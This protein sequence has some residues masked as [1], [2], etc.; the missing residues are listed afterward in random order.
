MRLTLITLCITSMLSQLVAQ[1]NDSILP[2]SKNAI[3]IELMGMSDIY[4]I[5]YERT[6]ST[7]HAVRI[8][9]SWLPGTWQ[10]NGDNNRSFYYLPLE[11]SRVYSNKNHNLVT[12]SAILTS[13]QH[14]YNSPNLYKFNP[15]FG[16]AYL[17]KNNWVYAKAGV[18]I[19]MPL[20]LS[21]DVFESFIYIKPNWLIWP[22]LGLGTTF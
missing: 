5:N 21:A 3:Y 20:Y 7:K 22:Q 4:A 19:N 2:A 16:L 15:R 13:I 6:L 1:Q 10:I 18:C 12:S 9:F 8:G 17:Y 11:L 14:G